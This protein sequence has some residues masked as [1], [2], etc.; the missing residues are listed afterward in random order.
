MAI[1]QLILPRGLQRVLA[2]VGVVVT[3]YF[4]DGPLLKRNF[5]FM[6]SSSIRTPLMS[7]VHSGPD[8]IIL[9]S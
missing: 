4:V 5:R 3:P 6:S 7:A 1:N 8:P 2:S 9:H